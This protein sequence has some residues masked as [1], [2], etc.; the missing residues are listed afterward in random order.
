[1]EKE[2]EKDTGASYVL[3]KETERKGEKKRQREGNDRG[4]YYN[5]NTTLPML[6]IRKR[7]INMWHNHNSNT[8]FSLY[9]LLFKT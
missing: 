3:L 1:M 2:R 6:N 9:F 7:K 4:P 8:L 5:L